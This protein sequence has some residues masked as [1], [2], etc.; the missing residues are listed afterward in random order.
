MER[1]TI[2]RRGAESTAPLSDVSHQSLEF[3]VRRRAG[4]SD[5]ERRVAQIA[6][7]LFDLTQDLHDLSHRA[8]WTLVAAALVHDV[9]KSVDSDDHARIGANILLTDP[10][11]ELSPTSRRWLAYLTLYHRGQVPAPGKAEIL[12]PSDDARGLL[13]VLGLLRAADT[14]D[15]RS[16]EA[17]RLL[18]MRRENRLHIGCYL[19]Q[20]DP[21]AFRAFC[22]PKKYRLLEQTLGCD[23]DVEVHFG[24]T[25][26]LSA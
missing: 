23:V 22:R 10:H 7:A 5:H 9:G 26:I 3:W 18:M 20:A 4:G 16:I 1:G 11:L 13:K 2:A 24:D 21:R 12:R 25:K 19:R 6:G 15:S 8:Q 17:P 14:L